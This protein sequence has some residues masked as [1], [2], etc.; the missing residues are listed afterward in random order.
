[1]AEGACSTFLEVP[2]LLQSEWSDG[3]WLAHRVFAILSFFILLTWCALF[4]E[5]IK[6]RT[7]F[8]SAGA[9]TCSWCAAC[10]YFILRLAAL[11]CAPSLNYDS[12]LWLVAWVMVAM[13]P[14]MPI[15]ILWQFA[16]SDV[17]QEQHLAMGF[18]LAAA[19]SAELCFVAAPYH[20]R[21]DDTSLGW[22][23]SLWGCCIAW[24]GV[25]FVAHPQRSSAEVRSPISPALV[26]ETEAYSACCVQTSRHILLG[27][28][29]A[30]GAA[31]L[32]LEKRR[33]QLD[34]PQTICE[35][36]CLVVAATTFA[37]ATVLL[38]TF[39]APGAESVVWY[40]QLKTDRMLN[41]TGVEALM[42]EPAALVPCA[43]ISGVGAIGRLPSPRHVGVTT[44][45]HAVGH[46][47]ASFGL[48]FGA[49]MLA[50]ATLLGG[51]IFLRTAGRRPR[52]TSANT[53]GQGTIVSPSLL[54]SDEAWRSI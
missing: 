11:M 15:N 47:L 42:G 39:P 38:F 30:V 17:V 16:M 8:F 18:L 6:L 29:I 40:D 36:P 53:A 13:K 3:V 50:C 51:Y 35:A 23:H 22:A 46:I 26:A 45:C 2:W 1:M 54:Q 9:A 34:V 14:C 20:V 32:A 31:A 48:W 28:C 5:L 44:T 25:L 21:R 12:G 49:S 24:V 10:P 33:G 41:A 27:V 37:L 19:G 52:K 7:A 4:L 43:N